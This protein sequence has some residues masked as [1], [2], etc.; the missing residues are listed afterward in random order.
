MGHAWIGDWIVDGTAMIGYGSAIG[1]WIG[2]GSA[3]ASLHDRCKAAHP[4]RNCIDNRRACDHHAIS[5][6]LACTFCIAEMRME[7]RSSF[8]YL[9]IHKA[10]HRQSILLVADRRCHCSTE[11]WRYNPDDVCTTARPPRHSIDNRCSNDHRGMW[12]VLRP[13]SQIIIQ[14]PKSLD[15]NDDIA[16]ELPEAL[17]FAHCNRHRV[18]ED[19]VAIP[20]G[21]RWQHRMARRS[22]IATSHRFH[23]G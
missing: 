13:I 9:F 8:S 15:A 3:M 6:H 4:P 7:A 12:R 1:D 21:P 16:I 19:N 5:E 20:H 18:D 2:D 10:P 14:A 17:H 23:L 22:K 11:E